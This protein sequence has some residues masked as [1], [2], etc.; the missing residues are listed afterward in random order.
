MRKKNVLHYFL[1]APRIGYRS[2]LF[3]VRLKVFS[4]AD[5]VL[6]DILL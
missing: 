1:G 5:A 2:G 4:H 3:G 6:K